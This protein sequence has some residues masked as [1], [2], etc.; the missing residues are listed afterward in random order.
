MR[1]PPFIE[2][3]RA[4]FARVGETQFGGMRMPPFI[5]ALRWRR[6]AWVWSAVR[7]HAHAALH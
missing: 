3:L 6:T 1:M 4:G 7:R 5:E 2:A